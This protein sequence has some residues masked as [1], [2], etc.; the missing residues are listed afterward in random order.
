MDEVDENCRV[1]EISLVF[2]VL[3]DTTGRAKMARAF[4]EW[5]GILYVKEV[6]FYQGKKM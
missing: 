2:A 1:R 3:R 6:G 4:M 5:G